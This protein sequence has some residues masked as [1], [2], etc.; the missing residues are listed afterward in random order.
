MPLRQTQS[1]MHRLTISSFSFSFEFGFAR[2]VQLPSTM[3]A[4]TMSHEIAPALRV[5]LVPGR[6]VVDHQ[7]GDVAHGDAPFVRPLERPRSVSNVK[8]ASN[9]SDYL[10]G[11]ARYT[12]GRRE[13]VQAKALERQSGR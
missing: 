7:L 11:H 9:A 3:R 5:S 4:R 8:N 2:H 6:E 1:A 13:H 12:R 10:R